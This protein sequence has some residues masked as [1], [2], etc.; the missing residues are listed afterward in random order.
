M[1]F[2]SDQDFNRL[3]ASHPE[4]SHGLCPTCQGKGSFLWWG[5]ENVCDCATQK[6]LSIL[7]S[8]AGIGLNYQ[9]LDWDDVAL[10]QEQLAPIHNYIND[11][12]RY[13][14]RGVGLILSGPIGT[15]KT[16]IANLVLKALVKKDYDCYFTTFARPSSHSPQPGAVSRTRSGFAE[17]F[18]HSKVLCLDDLGREFRSSNKLPAT[19]FDHILRTRVQ[20][21][22]PVILTTNL[23]PNEIRSG[24]GAGVLHYYWSSPRG[25]P[26]G[27]GFPPAGP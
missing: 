8:H 23:T 13:V 7:Y 12:D 2:L 21:C 4:I 5:D 16:L 6:Q 18:M 9:R 15:G 27:S 11:T 26:G 3:K 24:Y 25:A 22:R 1:R 14:H 19:T 10:S 17:R 20:N